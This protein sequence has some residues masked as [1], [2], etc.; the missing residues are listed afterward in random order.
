MLFVVALREHK[1]VVA[2]TLSRLPRIPVTD[3]EILSIIEDCF[4]LSTNCRICQQ[5]VTMPSIAEEQKKDKDVQRFYNKLL[6]DKLGECV[7][8]SGVKSGPACVRTA[9]VE[10]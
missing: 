9:A 2:D 4:D 10:Q 1:N 5:P 8:D 6:T 3:D 7:E